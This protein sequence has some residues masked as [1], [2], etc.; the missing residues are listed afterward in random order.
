MTLQ[1]KIDEI[2]S[3]R[4]S[5][6]HDLNDDDSQLSV[7]YTLRQIEDLDRTLQALYEQGGRNE[8]PY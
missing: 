5:Y 3:I 7:A 4:L 6:I 2:E 1:E 8:C